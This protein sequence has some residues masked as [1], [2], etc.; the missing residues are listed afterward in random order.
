MNELKLLSQMKSPFLVNMHYAFQDREN[1][2]LVM[3]LLTGGDLRYHIAR[4]RKFSEEQTRFFIGCILQALEV[5][6]GCGI[7]HRDIKPEN[8]VFDAEGYL[9]LTDFGI[10]RYWTPDNAQ[11]TSGTP[12]YMAPEVMCRQNHGVAADYFAV[13]V[14]AFE[15]MNGRRPYIG[16]SRREIREQ[17][18]AKQMQIKRFEIPE[19]WSLEAADFINKCLQRKPSNRIGLNG[20]HEVKSH[21]WFKDF[22]WQKLNDRSIS[23][24]FI[25]S[26]TADNFDLNHVNNNDWKDADLVKDN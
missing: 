9:R 21:A 1:L 24:P 17:I 15:C 11:E 14:I 2:Y 4:H 7:I 5:V 3:D 16:K 10:A 23:S 20:N 26:Q 18:L 12:G 19:G 6:H 8:L 25:P 13:G 22:N